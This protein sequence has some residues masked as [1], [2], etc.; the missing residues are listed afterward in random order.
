MKNSKTHAK[1]EQLAL[2]ASPADTYPQKYI[3]SVFSDPQ[4]AVD[5]IQALQTIGY[6]AQSIRF[7]KSQDYVQTVEQREPQQSGFFNELMHLVSSL[8]Y[9]FADTYMN[10]ALRGGHIMAVRL[11]G[12]EQIMKVR[13]LLVSHHAYLVKYIDTWAFADLSPMQ[14]R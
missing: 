3:H 6:D 14:V 4:D 7:L 13:D 12:H 9:G 10:E 5:A 1:N 8:D 2:Q 11:S